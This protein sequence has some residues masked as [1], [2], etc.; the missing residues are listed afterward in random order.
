MNP[1][2]YKVDEESVQRF[3]TLVQENLDLL[4]PIWEF[5]HI[6]HG[7]LLLF[8]S[9]DYYFPVN[10]RRGLSQLSLT[11][12]ALYPLLHSL[13]LI[14]ESEQPKLEEMLNQLH[15]WYEHKYSEYENNYG[16]EHTPDDVHRISEVDTYKFVPPSIRYDVFKRDKWRCLSCGR[17]PK[18][19][20]QLE[21]DHIIPGSKGG[22]L[23]MSNL[24]T[25]CRECNIGKSNRDSTDL[26]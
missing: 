12:A 20:V 8:S 4:L 19:G 6:S 5:H 3:K 1:F 14:G 18:D 25:L 26:R 15:M 23:V 24:Q 21:A 11:F 16:N 22:K 9:P 7:N 17:G 13:V 2:I 10:A